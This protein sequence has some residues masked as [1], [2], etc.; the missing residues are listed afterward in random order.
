MSWKFKDWYEK[1]KEG[2]AQKRKERYQTDPVYRQKVIE[3]AA[4]RRAAKAPP[5][6]KHGT[7]V[8][9]ACVLL[10]ITL[11]TLNRWKNEQY[12]PVATLRGYRFTDNQIQLLGLLKQFSEQ[13]PGKSAGLHREKL[14][15][16]VNVINHNWG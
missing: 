3:Q 5:A 8:Q 7:S 9:D 4:S 15:E 14:V 13:Y 11:W 12:F 16:L 10:G 2:L 1:N 6:P